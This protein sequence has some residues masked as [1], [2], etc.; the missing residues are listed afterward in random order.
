[1][2]LEEVLPALRD[3]AMIRRSD[4]REES[5][6]CSFQF[7]RLGELCIEQPDGRLTPCDMGSGDIMAEDWRIVT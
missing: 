1:M 6:I 5:G 4:P 7:N 2:R 3:G